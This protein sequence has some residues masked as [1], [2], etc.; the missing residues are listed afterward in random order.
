MTSATWIPTSIRLNEVRPR[1]PEQYRRLP[2]SP[3]RSP[4][5][6]KSGLEGR[7]NAELVGEDVAD[8]IVSMKSGLEGRNN[9]STSAIWT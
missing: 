1:R 8:K 2:Q 6:M 9:A 7:N 4:V 3:Q 5:S